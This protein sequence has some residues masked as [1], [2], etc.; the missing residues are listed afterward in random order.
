M[1]QLQRKSTFEKIYCRSRFSLSINLLFAIDF[2]DFLFIIKSSY[3]G[4]YYFNPNHKMKSGYCSIVVKKIDRS[5]M[6][7]WTC[8][9]RLSGSEHE[10]ADEFRVTVF[11][12]GISVASVSGMVVG[13][14]FIC[15]GGLLVMYLTYRKRRTLAINRRRITQDTIVRYI[16]SENV[17]ISGGSIDSSEPIRKTNS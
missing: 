2:I 5:H 1:K 11:N 4:N 8:A 16:D 7:Q 14:I 9:A 17:S 15:F 6:G 10:S 12:S 3:L 13:L